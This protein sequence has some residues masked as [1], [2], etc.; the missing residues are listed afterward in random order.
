M[1]WPELKKAKQNAQE[2]EREITRLLKEHNSLG[3]K[4]IARHNDTLVEMTEQ[5]LDEIMQRI[6][7]LEANIRSHKKYLRAQGKFLRRHYRSL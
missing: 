4:E 6:K 7:E 5:S 3:K 2:I 1:P